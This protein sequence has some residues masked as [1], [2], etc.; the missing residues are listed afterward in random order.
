MRLRRGA[1]ANTIPTSA[2]THD[3]ADEHQP[4]EAA[5]AYQ[6]AVE[7]EQD[8]QADVG[9]DILRIFCLKIALAASSPMTAA[10]APKPPLPYGPKTNSSVVPPNPAAR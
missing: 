3:A 7:D 4:A 9:T 5:E 2:P 10:A 6:D 8:E 1:Y